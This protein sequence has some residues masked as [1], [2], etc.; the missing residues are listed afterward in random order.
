[1]VRILPS[2]HC[3]NC[4]F[5]LAFVVASILSRPELAMRPM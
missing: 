5:I 2:S 4:G 3:A 1:M